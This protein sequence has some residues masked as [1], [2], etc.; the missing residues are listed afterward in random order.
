MSENRRLCPGIGAVRPGDPRDTAKLDC[1][2]PIPQKVQ[3]P[4][5]RKPMLGD[6]CR[7]PGRSR[8]MAGPPSGYGAMSSA[9]IEGD[10]WDAYVALDT[11]DDDERGIAYGTRSYGDGVLVVVVGVTPHQ[12]G[13]ESR[14]HG[15]RRTGNR[16]VRDPRGTRNAQSRNGIGHSLRLRSQRWLLES[17]DAVNVARP[18]RDAATGRASGR[19]SPP[20][21]PSA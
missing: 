7:V 6:R 16:N 10:E 5:R 3:M 12:G 15:R 18:V 21:S 11:Y 1:L 13:R 9:D 4:A 2:K 14:P 19:S 17:P 20:L 8:P